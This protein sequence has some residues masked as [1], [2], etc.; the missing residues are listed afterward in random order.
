MSETKGLLKNA[1][2]GYQETRMALIRKWMDHAVTHVDETDFRDE[3]MDRAR[4]KRLQAEYA[5]NLRELELLRLYED[6]TQAHTKEKYR[7]IT[8]RQ[9]AI[10]LELAVVG[11][12]RLERLEECLQL[13]DGL[14]T[15]WTDALQGLLAYR[16]GSSEESFRLLYPFLRSRKDLLR[17][18]RINLV[19][20]KLLMER[21]LPA[22]AVAPLRQAA[23]L[24]P[25]EVEAHLLLSTALQESGE[26]YAASIED[27]IIRLLGGEAHG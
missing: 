22:Q 14:E 17:H 23:Q 24:R 3:G 19:Y 9:A 13:L 25:E 21:G 12:E 2:R 8:E 20:G 18:Y 7:S 10:C 5:S 26:R 15:E 1:I 4:T 16:E 27:E 6:T 11:S